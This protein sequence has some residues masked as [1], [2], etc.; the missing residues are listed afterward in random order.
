MLTA[1]RYTRYFSSPTIRVILQIDRTR[2]Y[3][4]LGIG[5]WNN[6]NWTYF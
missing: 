5:P 6:N 1:T 2:S 3:L 4:V